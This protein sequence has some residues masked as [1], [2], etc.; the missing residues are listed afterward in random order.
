MASPEFMLLGNPWR[1]E[2]L[3]CGDVVAAEDKTSL[4]L[5]NESDKA[6][7]IDFGFSVNDGNG[8]PVAYKQSATPY[9]FGPRQSSTDIACLHVAKIFSNTGQR[10]PSLSMIPNDSKP[11]S[12]MR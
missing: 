4:F 7:D 11:M 2:I 3:P 8:K 5:Y 1:L 6:I 10:C 12:D 9:S